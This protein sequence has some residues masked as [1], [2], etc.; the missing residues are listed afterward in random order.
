[1]TEVSQ[2]VSTRTKLHF[3]MLALI[4]VCMAPCLMSYAQAQ[5]FADYP[6]TRGRSEQWKQEDFPSWLSLDM[7]IRLRTENQTSYQY[8]PGNNRVYQLTRVYG[9][10]TLQP[11]SYLTGY[12]HFIDTHALGLPVKH[13]AANMLRHPEETSSLPPPKMWITVCSFT[14]LGGEEN[15]MTRRFGRRKSLLFRF[16]GKARLG[17]A[18]NQDSDPHGSSCGEPESPNVEC[19][20]SHCMIVSSIDPV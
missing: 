20:F 6:Q 7:Q 19:L 1:M 18:H 8:I 10:L 5:V 12:M 15:S 9:G 2:H 14:A 17:A 13:I 4:G 3:C 11:T 16:L